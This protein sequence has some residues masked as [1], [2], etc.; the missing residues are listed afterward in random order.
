[1]ARNRKHVIYRVLAA[2]FTLL[3]GLFTTVSCIAAMYGPAPEY[4]PPPEEPTTETRGE[5]PADTQ[6]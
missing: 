5:A 1:M 2:F 6:P 4:G 3:V